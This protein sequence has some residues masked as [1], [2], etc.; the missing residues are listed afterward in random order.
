MKQKVQVPKK[1]DPNKVKIGLEN[2]IKNNDPYEK[3]VPILNQIRESILEA[4]Q[5][6]ISINKINK[7]LK[8]NGL[9]IPNEVL[10]KFLV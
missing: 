9:K 10:K 5:K 1:F 3:W 2:L 4:K 8:E 7:T 6:G